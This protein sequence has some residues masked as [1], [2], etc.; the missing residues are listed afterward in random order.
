MYQYTNGTTRWRRFNGRGDVR[1]YRA[2][3]GWSAS[4]EL[5]EHHPVSGE[6]FSRSDWWIKE[7]KIQ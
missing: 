2:P 1:A 6:F 4:A 3:K 7:V 5:I